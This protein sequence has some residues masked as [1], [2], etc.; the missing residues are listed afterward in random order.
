MGEKVMVLGGTGLVGNA[1]VRA[2]Q[3]KGCEVSAATYHCHASGGFLQL[4]MC[5][6]DQVR[7]LLA[8]FRP[9]L[10]AVP[11]ANPF[12]D[13]CELHPEET[14]KVNVAG[15]L[16]V[17]RACREL[18][19]RVIFYSSDYVFDGVKGVY[20]EEDAVCP[21]NE[22]GRQKAATEAGV[23]ASD[24][25]N[26]VLRTSGAYG[27][28]WEPKNFVLQIRKNLSE[29]KSMRVACDIRYNP[30]YVENLAEITVALAE[31]GAS[32]IFHAVG[33]EEIVR[34]EFAVRVAK[35]FGLDAGL[36]RPAPAAELG[37]PTPR[38]KES[39]LRTDKVRAA[40]RVQP[41][42][43]DEGLRRM[44]AAEP[45]WREYARTLPDPAAKTAPAR[46]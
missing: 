44:L 43:V 6:E 28:Q 35:A 13:H 34:H 31:A 46:R 21:I 4:D 33:A 2:W 42:G 27:W 39:S 41:I 26:L 25:R 15:T 38:P 1:L 12:V 7:A 45:A 40:I 36:L 5:G 10:V 37:S 29:G 20:T 19:A 9:S 11:A 30:T 17:A 24:P 23:T 18:G 22:Y 3:A 32:G 14:R 16:N 8:R